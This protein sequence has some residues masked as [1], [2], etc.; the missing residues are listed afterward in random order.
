[1]KE[2]YKKKN[3]KKNQINFLITSLKEE[4]NSGKPLLLFTH[5]EKSE[6]FMIFV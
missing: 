2:V 1:M 5:V 6:K 3:I 4:E